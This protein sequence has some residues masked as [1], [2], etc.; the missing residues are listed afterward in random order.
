M[1]KLKQVAASAAALAL[2]ASA[3]MAEKVLRIQS[4]LPNTA[5]EVYMLNEFGKDVA[6]LTNGS[7]TGD[8]HQNSAMAGCLS[9]WKK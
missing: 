4:V 8:S 6:A 2:M 7:L 9:L 3:A 1:F 5:D